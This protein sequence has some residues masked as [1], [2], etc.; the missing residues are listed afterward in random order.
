MFEIAPIFFILAF[1]APTRKSFKKKKEALLNLTIKIMK[2]LAKI[3]VKKNYNKVSLKFIIKVIELPVNSI[4][5]KN[6]GKVIITCPQS[7]LVIEAN[8]RKRMIIK[9]DSSYIT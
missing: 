2:V 9:L 4:I 7:K 1:T 8:L 3:I 6:K 5:K